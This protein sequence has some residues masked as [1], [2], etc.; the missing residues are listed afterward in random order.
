MEKLTVINSSEELIKK[1]SSSQFRKPN[2]KQKGMLNDYECGC[3][4][5]HWL[6]GTDGSVVVMQE[7]TWGLSIILRCNKNFITNV[8]VKGIFKPRCISI[9]SAP[10]TVAEDAFK[11]L[12]KDLI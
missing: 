7:Q 10:P 1:L 9:W 11:R 2:Y 6:D 5:F 3:G 12:F 8:H 4:D